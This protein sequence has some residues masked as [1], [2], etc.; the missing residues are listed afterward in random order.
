MIRIPHHPLTQAWRDYRQSRVTASTVA[1]ILG[2]S[3]WSSPLNEWARITGKYVRPDEPS[4]YSDW[5]LA[6]EF[7]HTR[8]F[9]TDHTVIVRDARYIV[10]HAEIPW[11][12]CTLDGLIEENEPPHQ[13]VLELKAPSPWTADEWH[14]RLPLPY[15]IQLQAQMACTGLGEAFLSVILPPRRDPTGAFIGLAAS[16]M[17]SEMDSA[18]T[19]EILKARGFERKDWYLEA[20]PKFQAAMLKR[21]RQWWADHVEQGIAPEAT[22]QDCDKDALRGL[23]AGN[24][25]NLDFDEAAVAQVVELEEIQAEIK[26]R[27]AMAERL[28]NALTQKAD[29]ATWVE[30]KKAIKEARRMVE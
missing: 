26:S 5:G 6:T 23:N 28:K 30:A 10:Q 7:V 17:G 19:V 29:V 9:E 4:V 16:L 12:C 1:A 21:L 25:A 2:E 3:K 8:W 18:E 24:V 13:C 15:Q 14:D 22:G 27:E 20:D 11:L